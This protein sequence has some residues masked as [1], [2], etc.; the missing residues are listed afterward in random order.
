MTEVFKDAK[1]Q[2]F[3]IDNQAE[4][5]SVNAG[6][7]D[8]GTGN[9]GIQIIDNEGGKIESGAVTYVVALAGVAIP[10]FM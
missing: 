8:V 9:G 10:L 1:V 4:A 7:P 6:Q 2:D 3:H 5:S